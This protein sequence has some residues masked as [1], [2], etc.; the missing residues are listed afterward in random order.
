MASNAVEMSEQM[1]EE[2]EEG[3]KSAT[4]S[5]KNRLQPEML[6]GVRCVCPFCGEKYKNR[7]SC[8]THRVKVHHDAVQV[9]MAP[10]IN[11]NGIV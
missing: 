10:L 2:D 9:S 1:G 8:N 11:V 7:K 4:G 5:K 3:A 6:E